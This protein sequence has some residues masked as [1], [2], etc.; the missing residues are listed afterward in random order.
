MIISLRNLSGERKKYR[1][2]DIRPR[3]RQLIYVIEPPFKKM[4]EERQSG[5]NRYRDLEF[6][7]IYEIYRVHNTTQI[8]IR[9]NVGSIVHLYRSQYRIVEELT[10]IESTLLDK[11]R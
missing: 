1:V 2:L 6:D 7:R 3:V 4:E 5:S 11:H 9:D 10:A 8:L